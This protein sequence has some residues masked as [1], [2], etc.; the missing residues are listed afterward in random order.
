MA[1]RV[2][3]IAGALSVFSFLTLKEIMYPANAQMFNSDK[4]NTVKKAAA[5]TGP[6]I[7]FLYW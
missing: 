4:M 7:K 1:T 2:Y 6:T 3:L 5:F